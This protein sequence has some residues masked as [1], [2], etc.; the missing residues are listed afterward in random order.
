MTQPSQF[1]SEDLHDMM[2]IQI[3]RVPPQPCHNPK[4]NTETRY[5]ILFE[6]REIGVW[7]DR[8]VDE[9]DGRGKDGTPRF[10]RWRRNPFAALRGVG[11]KP[12]SDDSPATPVPLPAEE[13]E[14]S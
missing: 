1:R 12:A 4:S 9:K 13:E 6:G 5:R 11:G 8:Y 2:I 10:R 7:R 14:S 3:E